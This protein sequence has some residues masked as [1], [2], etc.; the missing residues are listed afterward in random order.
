MNGENDTIKIY[1]VAASAVARTGLESVLRNDANIIVTGSAAEISAAPSVFSGSLAAID[2]LLMNIERRKDFLALSEFLSEGN[3][4]AAANLQFPVV[5]L[6]TPDFQDFQQTVQ[7]LH[8]GVR[9]ILP[10]DST[11]DEINAA[12]VAAANNLIVAAPEMLDALFSSNGDE[13]FTLSEES[14]LQDGDAVE[15]LTV[16]EREVLELLVEGASNKAIA[17]RMSISEHTVKFH[18]ASI[19][20]KLAVNSRTEAATQALRR[21]LILL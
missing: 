8:G 2:V 18:V 21:G 17:D 5:V 7:L 9:G 11:G 14:D 10:S 1:I 15:S 16:R 13:D 4:E 12:I 3:G 19:F 20:G 6:L